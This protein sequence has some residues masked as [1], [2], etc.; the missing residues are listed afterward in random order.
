M[1]KIFLPIL[2]L[3]VILMS[4]TYN[5]FSYKVIKVID[6]SP[7]QFTKN[8]NYKSNNLESIMTFCLNQTKNDLQFSLSSKQ[9]NSVAYISKSKQANCI[10]YTNYYNSML[11]KCLSE[12]NIDYVEV[13]HV[14]ALVFIDGIN[15][16]QFSN[17]PS[18]KD[19][20][21]SIVKNKKTGEVFYVDASL[22]E[23]FGNII[24]K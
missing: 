3:S 18:F 7:Q 1:K 19:H 2:I 8:V 17:D 15:M 21:I 12:N 24:V 14:R 20:D 5:V 23:M 6:S 13:T 10:G 11:S 4:F 16:H 22:S 9:N